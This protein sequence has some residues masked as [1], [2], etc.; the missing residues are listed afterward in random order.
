MIFW[1][2]EIKSSWTIGALSQFVGK[3]VFETT[4]YIP[5]LYPVPVLT[6]KMWIQFF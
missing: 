2:R 3:T 6:D 1:Q 4:P 5:Y